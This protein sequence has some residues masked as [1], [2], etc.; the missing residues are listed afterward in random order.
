MENRAS[1]E[2]IVN[3]LKEFP[4]EGSIAVLM[5]DMNNLKLAND[6]LGHQG[7]DKIISRFSQIIRDE[8]K[9]FGFIGRY[10]GD[11]FLA[12]FEKADEAR[13]NEYLARVGERIAA[14][15]SL[16]VNDIEKISFAAGVTVGSLSTTGI[17]DMIYEA[18][19]NMYANKRD[20]K[21]KM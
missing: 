19:R 14:Y 20:M 7:G 1:C 6:F 9:E 10:G 15:N 16:Q 3:Q 13:A 12:V 18:D 4:V 8:A 11:E 21:K 2:R 17:D 5:F